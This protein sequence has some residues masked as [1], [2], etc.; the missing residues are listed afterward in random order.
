MDYLLAWIIG[1]TVWLMLVFLL[2]W[3]ITNVARLLGPRRRALDTALKVLR[4]RLARQEITQAEYEEA[5]R[6]LGD[7]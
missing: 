4:G 3:L 1:V 5:R 7:G 2:F 6:I